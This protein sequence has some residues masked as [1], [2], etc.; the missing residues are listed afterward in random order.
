MVAPVVEKDNKKEKLQRCSTETTDC[1]TEDDLT[2]FFKDD[3]DPQEE[4][5]AKRGRGA[6]GTKGGAR[7]TKV[8]RGRKPK[9]SSFVLNI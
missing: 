3:E 4:T 7:D 2:T 9:V 6:R 8:T 1:S 5:R